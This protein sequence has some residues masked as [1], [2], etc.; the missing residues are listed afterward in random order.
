MN[1]KML[2]GDNRLTIDDLPTWVPTSYPAF[3]LRS[4]DPIEMF[5]SMTTSVHGY[6]GGIIEILQEALARR[7]G[8]LRKYL[9][10]LASHLAV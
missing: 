5:L 1:Q 10:R 3:P 9:E 2:R 4:S 7:P 6:E 8:L